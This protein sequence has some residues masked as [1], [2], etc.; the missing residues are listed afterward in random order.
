MKFIGNYD[1]KKVYELEV[2][3]PISAD[4]ENLYVKGKNI[5]FGGVKVGHLN[6]N[7]YKVLSYDLGIWRKKE[8]EKKMVAVPACVAET[9]VAVGDDGALYGA[10]EFFARVAKDIDDLLK[11]VKDFV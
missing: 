8:Q 4:T 3:D 7:N 2:Y 11:N 5:Y 9:T 10:D 6:P 1:K